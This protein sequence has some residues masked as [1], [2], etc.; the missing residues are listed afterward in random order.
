[1]LKN[2]P[3]CGAGG[4]ELEPKD[5]ISSDFDL[6]YIYLTELYNWPIW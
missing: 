5:E 4:K 6:F 3:F 1:V 2:F